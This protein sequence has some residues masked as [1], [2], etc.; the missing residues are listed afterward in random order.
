MQSLSSFFK[1]HR[2]LGEELQY[3]E[4][5]TLQ[6]VSA[7]FGKHE[8]VIAFLSALIHHQHFMMNEFTA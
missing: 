8:V 7:N 1:I 2:P 4:T 6:G 5:D 3:F